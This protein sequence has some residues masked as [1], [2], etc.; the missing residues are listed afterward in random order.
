MNDQGYF[1][2]VSSEPSPHYFGGILDDQLLPKCPVC[3][4]N[5]VCLASIGRSILPDFAKQFVRKSLVLM[6]CCRCTVSC[7]FLAYR[8]EQDKV[9][10]LDWE[11]DRD[12]RYK[13]DWEEETMPFRQRRKYASARPIIP[14]VQELIDR[15]SVDETAL[16]KDEEWELIHAARPHEKR[17]GLYLDA[18]NQVGATPYLPQGQPYDRCPAC[19]TLAVC[20]ASLSN[21][22]TEGLTILEPDI[23]ATFS[24]CRDCGCVIVGTGAT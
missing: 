3:N 15:V 18:N 10:I 4:E 7:G 8:V 24:M 20:I 16:S 5:L 11:G 9:A 21:N 12:D 23:Y 22:S 6:H 13:H 19:N 17:E 14:R 2:N 1:L